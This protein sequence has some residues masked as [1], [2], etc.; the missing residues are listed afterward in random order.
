MKCAR[1]QRRYSAWVDTRGVVPLADDLREHLA[2]CPRCAAFVRAIGRFAEACARVQAVQVPDADGRE[3]QAARALAE[4]VAEESRNQG[5]LARPQCFVLVLAGL[6][7]GG[8]LALLLVRLFRPDWSA[9]L[10]TILIAGG[11]AALGIESMLHAARTDLS[12]PLPQ[13]AQAGSA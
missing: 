13:K 7:L 6:L 12:E 5:M 9:L 1:Y 2:V 11:L 8:A 10:E 3:R 4:L